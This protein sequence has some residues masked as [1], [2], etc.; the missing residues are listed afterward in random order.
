[1]FSESLSQSERAHSIIHLI[2]FTV[3]RNISIFYDIISK[4]LN[5]ALP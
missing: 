1:M 4:R 5:I 2:P 3:N